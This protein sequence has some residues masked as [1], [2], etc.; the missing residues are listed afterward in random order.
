M[1]G[2]YVLEIDDIPVLSSRRF[3][4]MNHAAFDDLP[5]FDVLADRILPGAQLRHELAVTSVYFVEDDNPQGKL[6]A[7]YIV[8]RGRLAS[9]VDVL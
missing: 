7:R 4:D 8:R 9:P 1:S 2:H 5:R 6:L 3:G